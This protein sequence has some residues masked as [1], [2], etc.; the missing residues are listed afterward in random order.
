M[1][2]THDSLPDYRLREF[3]LPEKT[4]WE[5]CLAELGRR[6]EVKAA[7]SRRVV[8]IF[9]DTFDWRLYRR[10]QTLFTERRGRDPEVRLVWRET[11]G[12]GSA[13]LPVSE[14]LRIAAALPPRIRNRLLAAIEPRV[15]L[16][17]VELRGPVRIASVRDE[18]TKTVARLEHALWTVYTDGRA[19]GELGPRIALEALRGYAD[20]AARAA[21]TLAGSGACAESEDLLT[22]ALAQID[23][24]PGDY[25]SKLE[26]ALDPAQT[27]Q[28]ATT[29]VL[30]HLVETM[31][32]N[33][34][35][36]M[37]ATDPEFLHDF[38]VA[39]RRTRSLLAQAKGVFEAQA[40]APF[41]AEFGW[42]AE[43]TGEKRDLDVQLL[44][45]EPANSAPLAPL[46]EHLQ[47][48]RRHAGERLNRVLES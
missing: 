3:S 15:L 26:L 17:V 20:A 32:R 12:G 44:E 1:D 39:I 4:D 41:R 30:K 47:T 46:I 22:A 8:R 11:Q 29:V 25:S 37:A 35:G 40:L 16:A 43:Q 28:Q 23:R 36:T 9:Y 18:N 45:L 31:R 6:F 27:A 19:R 24:A 38:R 34:A 13:S 7:S 21:D 42:L 2:G 48:Q 33:Q 14:P 5:R 10:G